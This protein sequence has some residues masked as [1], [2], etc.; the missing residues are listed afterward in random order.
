MTIISNALGAKMIDTTIAAGVVK[1]LHDENE[2]GDR[3][4]EI[5]Q[6]MA[7]ATWVLL[8]PHHIVEHQAILVP[9][10]I[11]DLYET[12]REQGGPSWTTLP[13]TM[14]DRIHDVSF[15]FERDPPRK[16]VCLSAVTETRRREQ[17]ADELMAKDTTDCLNATQ[18]SGHRNRRGRLTRREGI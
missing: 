15:R 7:S 9:R 16:P 12:F 3:V 13:T 5:V 10:E 2:Y 11:A 18:D 4:Y 17:E 14:S 1:M 6:D 8:E